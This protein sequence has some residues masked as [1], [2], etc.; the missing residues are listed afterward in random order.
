MNEDSPAVATAA[1]PKVHP[2]AVSAMS[3]EPSMTQRQISGTFGGL[4]GVIATH[5]LDTM[6]VRLQTG[7]LFINGVSA[8]GLYQGIIPPL[9]T[10]TP[11]AIVV[12]TGYDLGLKYLQR[13]Y[14]N[15]RM[16]TRLADDLGVDRDRVDIAGRNFIA[17]A[18]A[19][20]PA[21][22]LIVPAERIK[23]RMQMDSSVS[24]VSLVKE[25]M[26]SHA[27]VTSAMN[28]FV[29]TLMRDTLGCGTWFAVYEGMKHYL[30]CR[31]ADRDSYTTGSGGERG[32]VQSISLPI[33]SI[34]ACGA[35][36]GA[37]SW[38]VTLPLD[39]LK[40]RIQYSHRDLRIHEAMR[41]LYEQAVILARH[42]PMEKPSNLAVGARVWR[43]LYRGYGFALMR[44]VPANAISWVAVEFMLGFLKRHDIL[45]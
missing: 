29:M 11:G 34:M 41:E 3:V 35:S 6:R 2:S 4:C 45:S 8:R 33:T 43:L 17:G 40:S 38:T 22:P 1:Q 27:G 13:T 42:T 37:L 44:S 9:L 18:C 14:G 16:F 32:N 28:G 15:E 24:A 26:A 36:A 25:M 23:I 5:P 19:A 12:F 39:T 30:R 31:V 7:R 10:V 20:I 21:L